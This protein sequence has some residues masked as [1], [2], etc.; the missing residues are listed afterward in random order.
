MCFP[1][2][3][4]GISSYWPLQIE[5]FLSTKGEKVK[6]KVKVHLNLH[7]VVSIEATM[8][9]FC[10]EAHLILMYLMI[11]QAHKFLRF[12]AVYHTI[13]LSF[14][15]IYILMLIADPSLSTENGMFIA[16]I[17]I[18]ILVGTGVNLSEFILGYE[19]FI[20]LL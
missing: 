19:Q 16:P 10:C 12:C 7:G 8:V 5:P 18:N 6:L 1:Y 17:K 3:T 20:G 14:T 15:C 13:V 11:S 2:L 4:Y 9:S